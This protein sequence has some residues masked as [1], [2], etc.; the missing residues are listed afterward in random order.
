MSIKTTTEQFIEKSQKIHNNKYDYSL[1]EYEGSKTKVKIICPE[2]G[3]FEQTP[4]KHLSGKGCYFCGKIRS[5]NKNTKNIEYNHFVIESTKV[6]SN[7]YTYNIKD[8]TY[9]KLYDKIVVICP[10]HGE[11]TQTTKNHLS[12]AGCMK[13][14]NSKNGKNNRKITKDVIN[15]FNQ[16]HNNKY[17]YS[18]VDY[19]NNFTKVK[20]ICSDHGV[21]EQKP[22]NHLSGQGCPKC[23]KMRKEKHISCNYIDKYTKYPELGEE[24]GVIYLMNFINNERNE[25]FYKIGI[26]VNLQKRLNYLRCVSD[27]IVNI[28]F[29]KEMKN[30]ECAI[31]EKKLHNRFKDFKYIPQE[32]FNG[33]TE[34]FNTQRGY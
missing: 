17:D 10:T 5:G 3:E 4:N 25:N 32:K 6:H 24:V 20:I 18:L 14:S 28:T 15:D 16:T 8:K 29:F 33:W 30:I 11:F 12:G 22:S 27:Y 9:L 31:L 21:F 19:I 2:H 1:T 26:T 23:G 34:C 7:K 13:C